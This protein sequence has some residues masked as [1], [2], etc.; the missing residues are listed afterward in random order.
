[1]HTLSECGF[2]EDVMGVLV[3]DAQVRAYILDS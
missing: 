2:S 1:M 3:V